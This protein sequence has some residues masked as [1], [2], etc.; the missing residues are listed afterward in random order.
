MAL[1]VAPRT[2]GG[3]LT[4][5]LR[6][7]TRHIS[8]IA[9]AF[10]PADLVRPPALSILKDDETHFAVQGSADKCGCRTIPSPTRARLRAIP[11]DHA[12]RAISTAVHISWNAPLTGN[13]EEA[14]MAAEPALWMP[15]DPGGTRAGI[16]SRRTRKGGVSHGTFQD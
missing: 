1:A 15:V 3:S 9:H 5:V 14:G 2:A 7:W 4:S 10:H 11:G 16:A 12:S 6:S 8:T 13:Q